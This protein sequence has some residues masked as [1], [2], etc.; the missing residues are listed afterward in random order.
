MGTYNGHQYLLKLNY[1]HKY[2]FASAEE[3]CQSRNGNL[4]LVDDEGEWNFIVQQAGDFG[5]YG[6]TH[7]TK[8]GGY[9][10]EDGNW[11]KPSGTLK[12]LY[13]MY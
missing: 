9:I 10:D 2:S 5:K 13:C 4:L 6:I 8:I 11:L 3:M 1:G 7:H 12:L